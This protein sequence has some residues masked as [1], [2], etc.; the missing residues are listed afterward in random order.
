MWHI[1][2][3]DCPRLPVHALRVSPRSAADFGMAAAEAAAA[4]DGKAAHA[5]KLPGTP[6]MA[7][8]L[9]KTNNVLQVTAAP[10]WAE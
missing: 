10:A 6:V 9:R 5:E 3:T 8:P 7:N 1:H 4:V 2:V